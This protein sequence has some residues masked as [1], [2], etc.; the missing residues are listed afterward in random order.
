MILSSDNEIF[1]ESEGF[2][3]RTLINHVEICFEH[4][5]EQNRIRWNIFEEL[6]IVADLEYV[7]GAVQRYCI[8]ALIQIWGCLCESFIVTPLSEAVAFS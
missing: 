1:L 6:S 3:A 5:V 2:P 4:H 7:A 8:K